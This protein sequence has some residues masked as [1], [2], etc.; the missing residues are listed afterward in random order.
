[1]PPFHGLDKALRWLRIQSNLKQREVAEAAGVTQAMLCAYEQGKRTPSLASLEKILSSLGADLAQLEDALEL[2]NREPTGAGRPATEAGGGDL[3]YP[4][5]GPDP[6]PTCVAE[7][8][9]D[10]Y[11]VLGTDQ[12]LPP[13]QE[14]ALNG[15]L[16]GFCRWLRL[17]HA[18]TRK[19][20]EEATGDREPHG[21]KESR[22]RK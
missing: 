9:V 1:M 7:P 16:D 4:L 19:T 2:V 15:L 8:P 11:Q 5:P 18:G 17:L 13:E 14:A 21:E 6:L 20:A 3:P 10:L 22:K 12:R